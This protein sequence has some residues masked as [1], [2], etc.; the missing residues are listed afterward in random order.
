MHR[1]PPTPASV[2]AGNPPWRNKNYRVDPIPGHHAVYDRNRPDAAVRRNRGS[3]LVEP[4][5]P[6]RHR[7]SPGVEIT[8]DPPDGS[9]TKSLRSAFSHIQMESKSPHG[10]SS[11]GASNQ[12]AGS[13]RKSQGQNTFP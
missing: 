7:L 3:P 5:R 11:V 13:I 10:A 8:V 12:A 9:G 1:G 6:N 2:A 4:P